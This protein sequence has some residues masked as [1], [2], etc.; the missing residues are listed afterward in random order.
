[1]KGATPLYAIFKLTS[2]IFTTP[3]SPLSLIWKNQRFFFL[4]PL[5]YMKGRQVIVCVPAAQRI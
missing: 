3:F 1:M 2:I 4:L 5:A